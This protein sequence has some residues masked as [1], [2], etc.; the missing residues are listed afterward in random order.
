MNEANP[1]QSPAATE[2]G[3]PQANVSTEPIVP[4]P[5]LLS[6]AGIAA[7]VWVGA[8]LVFIAYRTIYNDGPT[9]YVTG[10]FLFLPITVWL[11][12]GSGW[13]GIRMIV[14]AILF[15]VFSRLMGLFFDWDTYGHDQNVLG[16]SIIVSALAVA[17]AD[18][19]VAII[20]KDAA[21]ALSMTAAQA[22]I[23]AFGVCLLVA[24]LLEKFV[25]SII[26]LEQI[27]FPETY[28][29]TAISMAVVTLGPAVSLLMRKH[30]LLRWRLVGMLIA[31]G[32][33]TGIACVY[34]LLIEGVSSAI[35]AMLAVP[36]FQL[37]CAAIFFPVDYVL[38]CW[39][40]SLVEIP[41]KK[42]STELEETAPT[43]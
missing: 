41:M 3:D 26:R 18:A 17:F 13:A 23:A 30:A 16:L 1:F 9:L 33:L 28:F 21:R 39:G 43:T 5:T 37:I 40:T 31:M 36:I 38:R 24:V 10:L 19:L 2:T 8:W 14:T 25:S 4:Q 22:I 35:P 42:V 29:V 20:A 12:A 27:E 7:H 32:S 34:A 6:T 15:F 11:G